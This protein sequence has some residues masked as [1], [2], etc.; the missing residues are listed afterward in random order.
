MYLQSS[1]SW[2]R[3]KGQDGAPVKTARV[4]EQGDP[5]L[6]WAGGVPPLSHAQF[7]RVERWARG[8]VESVGQS[9]T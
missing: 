5:E 9:C 7:V 8:I 6:Y 1:A 3:R 4:K 2:P